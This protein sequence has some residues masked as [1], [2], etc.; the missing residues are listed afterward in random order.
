MH[1]TEHFMFSQQHSWPP[2]SRSCQQSFIHS[3]LV[4]PFRCHLTMVPL[5]R[6][7]D[8]GNLISYGIPLTWRLLSTSQHLMFWSPKILPWHHWQYNLSKLLFDWHILHGWGCNFFYFTMSNHDTTKHK[9]FP[10]SSGNLS[11]WYCSIKQD[12]FLH[13]T[14]THEPMLA[15]EW[16]C[17]FC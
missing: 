11:Q 13:V 7:T 1:P 9:A 2:V 12:L 5:H 3:L 17:V 4:Q 16:W 10:L 8:D 14:C 6:N 15:L